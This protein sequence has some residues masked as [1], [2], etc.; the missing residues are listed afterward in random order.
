LGEAAVSEREAEVLALLGERLTNAEIARRLFISVRTVESH[1]SSLLRKLDVADRRA[2]AELAADHTSDVP[3]SPAGGAPALPSSLTSFVGRSAERKELAALLATHRLVTAVGPGGVGK[4]RLA[5]AVASDVADRYA[6]GAWYVDLVPVTDVAMVGAAVASA[7]GFGEQPGR[8]P[9]ETV[10]SKLASAEALVVLD[11]CEHLVDGVTTFVEQVL[12]GCPLVTVLATSR[13]RLLVPHE[14]VFPVPGMSLDTDVGRGDA[15]ELFVQ[16]AAMAGWSSAYDSDRGRIARICAELDGVALSIEL[17]AARLVTLGIDGLETGLADQLGLLSG[18]PRLDDRHRSARSALDWSYGLLD[19]TDRMVL[20]STSVFTSPFSTDAAATV[21]AAPVMP[22]QVAAALARL[23]DHNLLVAIAAPGGTRYRML[24]TIRQYGT[25][26]LEEAGELDDVLR[27]H[28][29]WCLATATH[30][31]ASEP[32]TQG[33]ASFL[34]VGDDL[35]SALGWATGRPAHWAEA[36]DLA[37]LLARLTYARGMPSESQERYEQAAAV[38]P[39]PAEAAE[40]LHLA[41]VVAWGRHIGG[42]AIRLFHGAAEY[43]LEAGD[44]RRAALELVNAAEIMTNAPGIMSEL[45]AP[46][47]AEALLDE[48]RTLAAGHVH[49][50]ASILTVTTGTDEFDPAYADLAERAVELAHR[51]GDVRLESH[52]LDQVTAVRLVSGQL[53][54]AVTAALRR[55]ELVNPRTDD[56]EMAWEHSDTLHMAPLVCLAAGDLRAAREYAQA[57]SELPFLREAD[58]LA[59]E[60]LLPTSAIAGDFDEAVVFAERFR[61][62]YTEAGRPPIGGIGFAPAAA[63]MVHGIR[64]EEEAHLEWL[65]ITHEIRRVTEPMRGRET[66]YSP[67]FEGMVALHRGDIDGALAQVAGAPESYKPWHDS[68]WRPWYTA[69]WAESA[70]LAGLPDRRSRL[71]RARF[72]VRENPIASAMVDR[73]DALDTGDTDRLLAAA[74]TLRD[75]G[76]HYQ[77]ARTL[78]LAGGEARTAGEAILQSIGATPIPV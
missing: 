66:I 26:R 37:T 74:D 25:R 65:E 53:S 7:F 59:V 58:H 1:V 35:R 5:L 31:E 60:W 71:E 76:C 24:E 17:A 43:A 15:E 12:K 75:A 19:E 48:A 40:A 44:A 69:V 22:G 29:A 68:A 33:E 14:S 3:T 28:L 56:P 67:A 61:R 10:V 2:L 49:V 46:G 72:I 57:R 45:P 41:G 11:N 62:G 51:V 54:E 18:G 27:R 36:F 9:V 50:E 13:V 63:A 20:S 78:V 8:S 77:R 39:G 4:T 64:G 34:E 30:L 32:S 47:A 16:R 73:A 21:T 42:E 52:A 38:A 23:A 70:V 6:D 55:L